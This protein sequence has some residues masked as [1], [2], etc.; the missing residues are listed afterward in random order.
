MQVKN[1][2][3]LFTKKIAHSSVFLD[4]QSF[5]DISIFISNI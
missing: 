2:N 4:S 1:M 3:V 5:V